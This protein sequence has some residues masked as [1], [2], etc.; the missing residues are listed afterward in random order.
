MT[1]IDLHASALSRGYL[2]AGLVTDDLCAGEL[3]AILDFLVAAAAQR[4]GSLSIPVAWN[5][6]ALGYDLRTGQYSSEFLDWEALPVIALD[7]EIEL[8]PTGALAAFRTGGGQVPCEV[9]HR[10]GDHPLLSPDGS[11]PAWLSGAPAG[12]DASP[13]HL[14]D[15]PEGLIVAPERLVLD[16]FALGSERRQ[17]LRRLTGRWLGAFGHLSV[18]TRYA[19]PEQ[20]EMPEA[21]LYTSYL[22]TRQKPLLEAILT[23]AG[24]RPVG[25]SDWTEAELADALLASLSRVDDLLTLAGLVRWREQAVHPEHYERFTAS[26]LT[27]T[28]DDVRA[29]A[30]SSAR[31]VHA[32][33]AR[34]NRQKVSSTAYIAIGS[35][36][37][38]RC[39]G[40]AEDQFT[41]PAYPTTLA[42]AQAWL[43]EYLELA[44]GVVLVAG[45]QV[46]I[47]L[48]D[49]WQGGGIWRAELVSDQN[50]QA[51]LLPLQPGPDSGRAV[52]SDLDEVDLPLALGW[53]GFSEHLADADNP[54]APRVDDNGTLDPKLDSAHHV[55]PEPS[56]ETASGH[57]DDAQ[58]PLVRSDD[59]RGGEPLVEL[60]DP[61]P[62]PTRSDDTTK[63]WT[64]V[65]TDRARR[66]GS[67]PVT[68][69]V[70]DLMEDL[71]LHGGPLQ[72]TMS[73]PGTDIALGLRRQSVTLVDS[74]LE[75]I[76]WP[77]QMFTGLRL[78]A[79]WSVDGYFIEVRSTPLA[80][81]LDC[82]GIP[83]DYDFDEMVVLRSWGS[84]TDLDTESDNPVGPA[85]VLHVLRQAGRRLPES[86]RAS[87]VMGAAEILRY[88]P[89]G[90]TLE[91]VAVAIDA[92]TVRSSMAGSVVVQWATWEWTASSEGNWRTPVTTGA[93]RNLDVAELA[94]VLSLAPKPSGRPSLLPPAT[95]GVVA[96]SS[97]RDYTRILSSGTPSARN[98]QKALEFAR[99]QGIDPSTL[100][101]RVTYVRPTTVRPY[102]RK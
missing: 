44:G 7:D 40:Q 37:R 36:L 83:L 79:S 57:S 97:R 12:L 101:P 99:S 34:R 69:L 53:L 25:T 50:G 5:C 10:E 18:R 94:V 59:L 102:R 30:L 47:R 95:S 86:P 87:L 98:R 92:L 75:G 28:P 65:L 19:S 17:S 78:T 90:T 80:E 74:R 51:T 15:L 88:L 23:G 64:F 61:I 24:L 43:T 9:V 70:R 49:A 1:G 100:H 48:D 6:L 46:H 45:Q 96:G 2:P 56:S 62:H 72:M 31:L 3:P 63:T 20:A 16:A 55:T 22:L 66:N 13:R 29:F 85:A 89:G 42:T 8:L 76:N 71:G 4:G 32:E 52:E 60:E 11:C 84:P 41:G 91:Q 82:D 67:L 54:A 35:F 14:Q 21:R 68:P 58:Q 81:P 73:H 77:A 27:L 38:D 39:G 33:T 26:R 93:R